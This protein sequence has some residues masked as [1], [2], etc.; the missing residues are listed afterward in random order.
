MRL[1]ILE[2]KFPRRALESV[3]KSKK[4]VIEKENNNGISNKNNFLFIGELEISGKKSI[5]P[6]IK[7]C[8]SLKP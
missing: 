3:N 1:S 8:S 5:V 6:Y 4:N 7:T 2:N